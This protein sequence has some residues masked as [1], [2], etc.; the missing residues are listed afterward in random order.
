M[1]TDTQQAEQTAS[2]VYALGRIQPRFPSLGVEKEFLQATGRTEREA[3]LTDRQVV[4]SVLRAN[5]YIARQ[6]CWVLSI[7]GLDTYILAPRYP[8]DIDLLLD[9]ARP[10]PRAT[11]IDVVIGVQGPLAP[12]TACNGLTVPIVSS[13]SCTP[14]TSTPWSARSRSRRAPAV[15]RSNRRP[16]S[17]SRAWSRSPTTPAR[18]TGTGR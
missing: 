5:R 4:E 14:S 15:T 3:D 1:T 11:D 6:V 9:A 13:T 10:A 16:R 12:P 8:D 17:C 2:Y 7:E 18:R